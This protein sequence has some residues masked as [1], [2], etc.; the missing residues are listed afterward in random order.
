MISDQHR[1]IFV[2]V[3]K[4]AGSSI[5][6][7]MG[8]TGREPRKHWHARELKELIE[9]AVWDSYFKFSF[10]RNPW[11]RMVSWWSMID[12][13]R[14]A[15]EAGTATNALIVTAC[16]RCSTFSD[17]L[18]RMDDDVVNAE[19]GR[20]WNI[21]TNQVDYV[22]DES[23]ALLVDFVGRTETIDRDITYV[24]AHLVAPIAPLPRFNASKRSANYAD[25]YTPAERDLV[26]ERFA[27]DV[28][29]FGYRFG[30]ESG[31]PTR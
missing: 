8:G 31:K 5:S 7:A 11:D 30:H 2:H 17:F 18:A 23:G 6:L 26:G 29:Y 25:Y 9:P 15:V 13:H 14:A 1:A 10:V 22:T 24:Q 20:R 19:N 27:R 12:G 4:T 21:W 28:A 16:R 3:Q